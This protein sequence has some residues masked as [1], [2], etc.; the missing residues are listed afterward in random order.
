MP[1][2]RT[3]VSARPRAPRG[4]ATTVFRMM[5]RKA[6]TSAPYLRQKSIQK[7][8][9][10]LQNRQDYKAEH[11]YVP[12]YSELCKRYAEFVDEDGRVLYVGDRKRDAAA[13]QAFSIAA[14]DVDQTVLFVLLPIHETKTVPSFGWPDVASTHSIRVSTFAPLKES[15]ATA[16]ASD[17]IAHRF[18]AASY[19]AI[20]RGP[21]HTLP[22]EFF[23]FE[24]IHQGRAV[25]VLV[26][27]TSSVRKLRNTAVKAKAAATAT[28]TATAA[29]PA[30]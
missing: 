15:K 17:Q 7:A 5:Q 9:R 1:P 23:E 19:Q 20:E 3:V 28:A 11:G 25:G 12:H 21:A 6:Q 27:T 14:E 24:D 10:S 29:A 2:K 13:Y 22:V 16:A 18:Q 26:V 8:E 4:P 30:T